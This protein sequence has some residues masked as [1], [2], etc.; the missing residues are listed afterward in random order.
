MQA[1]K[2]NEIDVKYTILKLKVYESLCK[3][4]ILQKTVRSANVDD[5]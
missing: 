2:G 5:H 4:I 1:Q 3:T